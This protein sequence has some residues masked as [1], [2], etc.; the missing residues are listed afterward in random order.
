MKIIHMAMISVEIQTSLQAISIVQGNISILMVCMKDL[1][2][3]VAKSKSA[4]SIYGTT[5]SMSTKVLKMNIV[6]IS[7]HISIFSIVAHMLTTTTLFIS[8]E[9]V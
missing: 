1:I 7:L 8:N 3:S 5:S 9:S 4:S 2:E 6:H